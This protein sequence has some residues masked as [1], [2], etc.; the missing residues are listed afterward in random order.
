VTGGSNKGH[1]S[2]RKRTKDFLFRLSLCQHQVPPDV[3]KYRWRRP[4]G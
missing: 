4:L 2:E 3:F 1:V